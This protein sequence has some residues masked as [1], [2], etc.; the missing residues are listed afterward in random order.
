MVLKNLFTSELGKQTT[1]QLLKEVDKIILKKGT[2]KNP[3][4]LLQKV[5]DVNIGDKNIK[6]GPNETSTTIKDKRFQR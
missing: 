3:E 4:K 1:K 6:V 5:D 2:T